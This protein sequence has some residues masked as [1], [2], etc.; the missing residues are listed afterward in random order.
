M[1]FQLTR[2]ALASVLCLACWADLTQAAIVPGERL[3]DWLLRN[4]GPGADTTALHWQVQAERA[5]QEQLRKAVVLALQ[6]SPGV[7]LS[8]EA[9]AHL[10]DW[11]LS[12]P[13]T[14]RLTVAVADAR[15]LQSAP[16]QDPILQ[17]GHLVVLP[18]RPTT[19]TVVTESGQPCS[20]THVSGALIQDYLRACVGVEATTEVDWAWIAQADGRTTRYG[21][22]AWNL[23]PQAEPGPGAWIWAPNRQAGI[24]HSASDNLARFLATQLPGEITLPA[25]PTQP[26]AVQRAQT[27]APRAAQATASDWGEIGLLQTPTARMAPSGEVRLHMSHVNP[28]TSGKIGRAHV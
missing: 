25:G 4:A 16:Q 9:R 10:S 15:W 1:K 28:Y 20:A 18:P 11:L 8:A 14:G 12:L 26:V 23:A 6:Q 17:D 7:T 21:I 13:L 3:S 19:V 2:T 24:P 27:P 5:P 22:A